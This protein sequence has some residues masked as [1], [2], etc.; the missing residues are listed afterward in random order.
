M[1]GSKAFSTCAD[2][3][4]R[5]GIADVARQNMGVGKIEIFSQIL[6]KQY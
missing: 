4:L 3:L 1:L 2:L 6:E 5:I